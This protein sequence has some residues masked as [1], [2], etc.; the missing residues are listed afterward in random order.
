MC[1][2]HFPPISVLLAIFQAIPC[3]F[4]IF[5]VGQIS[6]NIPGRTVCVSHFTTSSVFLS[7]NQVLSCKFLIFFFFGLL[8]YSR[9]YSVHFSFSTFLSVFR[10]NTGQIVFVSHFPPLSVFLAK[11]QVLQCEFLIF[12]VCQFSRHNPC[13]TVCISHFTRFSVFLTIFHLLHCVFLI[14]HDF[15]FSRHI[16][17]PTMCNCHFQRF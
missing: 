3:E 17:G 11:I 15:Q 16:P 10:H 1:V 13:P 4:L 9:S 6:H 12:L 7:I 5:L 14:Y 8:P 2:S